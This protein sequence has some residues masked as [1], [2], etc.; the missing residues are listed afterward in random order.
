MLIPQINGDS[1]TAV[2]AGVAAS[3]LPPAG[4]QLVGGL[5]DAELAGAADTAA[6]IVKWFVTG[7]TW[8]ADKCKQ[9]QSM[10]ASVPG[11]WSAITTALDAIP[12]IFG[13][14]SG[15]DVHYYL[16]QANNQT[17]ARLGFDL[18][19]TPTQTPAP[20][21]T[22]DKTKLLTAIKANLTP[23]VQSL[24]PT[25]TTPTAG[26]YP[27]GT[28]TSPSS[29]MP[30][31]WRVAIPRTASAGFGIATI[32]PGYAVPAS[33][34]GADAA[35]T[36]VTPVAAPPAGATQVSE[37]QLEKQTGQLPLYKN[38][39]FWAAV[40]GGVIVVGGLIA[41]LSSNEKHQQLAARSRAFERGELFDE[42]EDDDDDLEH[43]EQE[44]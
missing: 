3:R 38:W 35:F 22:V 13:A 8:G 7:V 25:S 6:T 41:L 12:S 29:K 17:C 43:D 37:A 34:L 20:T 32:D 15:K 9:L 42:D 5:S 1:A 39:M 24:Q 30:G 33:Q 26:Q 36:E 2:L 10:I 11:G 44:H 31:M 27:A 18:T 28:I 19:K 40:G 21:S 4:P 23:I 16:L 14:P